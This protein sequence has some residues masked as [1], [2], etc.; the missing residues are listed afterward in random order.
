MAVRDESFSFVE[1]IGYVPVPLSI[2]VRSRRCEL[3]KRGCTGLEVP[4]RGVPPVK[5]AVQFWRQPK[6]FLSILAMYESGHHA[7]AQFTSQKG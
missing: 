5:V 3:A 1:D 6:R 7:P 4:Y 2:C